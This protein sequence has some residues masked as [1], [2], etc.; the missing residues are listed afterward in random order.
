[1]SKILSDITVFSKYARHLQ[2]KNR[3]ETWDEIVSRNK[4]M[5][6]KKFPQLRGEIEAVYELVQKKQLL[7][8]MRSMQFAGPAI[9]RNPSRI[10]N[11]AFLPIDNWR[12]FS[13]V[14]FLLLGG[15][16]VGYSVQ[17]HHVSQLPPIKR[18]PKHKTKRYLVGDSLEGWADAVK[19]VVGSYFRG[20]M[21]VELDFGDIRPKGTPLKTAGGRAP[22]PEPLKIAIRQVASILNRK[23]N[24]DKLTTLEVHDMICHLADAVLAGGIRRSA[25]IA[26]CSADDMDMVTCKSGNWWELNPQRGRANNSVVLLRHRITKQVFG[27]LWQR[28]QDS[29][30]G[31][32]GI[33]YSN[34]KQWGTNP[35]SEIALRPF[36]MCNLCDIN[37]SDV[38]SQAQLEERAAAA[39][40]IGTLQASYTGFHYLRKVWQE[41]VEKD[42]LIGIGMTG[43]AS[44]RVLDLDMRKA[45][46]VAKEVNAKWSKVIGINPAARTTTVK[47]S[48]TSSLVLGC[49]SGIHAWHSDYFLRR[50]RFGKDEPIAKYLA[51]HAPE[52]LED[53][54]FKPHSQTV[55][56]VP[57]KAPDGAKTRHETATEFLARVKQVSEEWVHPGHRSGDNTNNVS[58]TISVRPEEWAE[59][60][61]WM[62]QNRNSFNGLSVLPYDGGTYKQA[63]FEEITEDKYNELVKSLPDINLENVSEEDDN[64]ELS[65]EPACAGGKCDIV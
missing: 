55:L 63:P 59:V 6:I 39:A 15:T 20:D 46:E 44:G 31:E 25:L 14:M 23:N 8:S 32:P 58:A 62:W 4:Q 50:M 5:H 36:Q 53:D 30:S 65:A 49:S 12:A 2:D 3:R 26:L 35:C 33:Y 52:L 28:I 7:P 34:D 51:Q 64:T 21:R 18:P 40:F 37:V 38:E 47:P 13:E 29:G 16:G 42:A 27:E 56:S 10:F 43:I 57:V 19:A 22:G 60:G 41:T 48:G 17:Q 11:C 61:E 54:V 24:G 45:A 9:E 1:M